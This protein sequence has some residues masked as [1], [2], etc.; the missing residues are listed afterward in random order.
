M[1]IKTFFDTQSIILMKHLFYPFLYCIYSYRE[2]KMSYNSMI[3]YIIFNFIILTT[4][5]QTSDELKPNKHAIGKKDATLLASLKISNNIFNIL[6]LIS[7]F[8]FSIF[9]SF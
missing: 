7:A 1:D 5:N 6:L 2:K 3:Q 4:T 9:T 8:P